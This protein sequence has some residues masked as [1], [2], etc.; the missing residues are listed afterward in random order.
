MN[1]AIAWFDNEGENNNNNKMLWCAVLYLF[2]S[3]FHFRRLPGVY[4][5]CVA[6]ENAIKI[7]MNV[8]NELF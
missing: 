7:N 3:L 5:R 1:L 4:S 6:T 2:N 8:F